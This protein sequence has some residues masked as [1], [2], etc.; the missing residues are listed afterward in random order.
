MG[1][2]LRIDRSDQI[3]SQALFPSPPLVDDN[4]TSSYPELLFPLSWCGMARRKGDYGNNQISCLQ[5]RL[6]GGEDDVIY[7]TRETV[8]HVIY[9][10][11]IVFDRKSKHREES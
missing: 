4:G 11:K 2:P 6:L 7:Q 10:T 5:I 3:Q 1:C 8:S 9:K